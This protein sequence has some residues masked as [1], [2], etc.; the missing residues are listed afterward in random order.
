VIDISHYEMV[1]QNFAETAASGIVAVILKATQ[2]TVF[3]DPTFLPHVAEARAAGLLVGAYHF[4]D[5]S[6][7][8]EQIAA[9]PDGREIR[10]QRQ[11]ASD[12]LGTI[13][14]FAG[15][16]MAVIARNNISCLIG[17]ET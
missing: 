5:G 11:L 1:S 14:T 12:R 17:C 9:L 6:S 16:R 3:V 13:P 2:G 7:P 10:G 4:L 15:E 8:A